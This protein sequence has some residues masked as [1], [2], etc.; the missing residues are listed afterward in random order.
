LS[1]AGHCGLHDRPSF[2]LLSNR[3]TVHPRDVNGAPSFTHSITSF[4]EQVF[5]EADAIDLVDEH[6]SS[7]KSQII[8]GE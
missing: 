2:G 7:W 5:L 1:G 3:Q 4:A 6:G 8:P